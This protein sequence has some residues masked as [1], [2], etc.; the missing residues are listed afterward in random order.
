MLRR[1][2]AFAF[3][4]AIVASSVFLVVRREQARRAEGPPPDTN[5]LH[6]A[7]FYDRKVG[8]LVRCT[9]CPNFCSLSDGQTGI[10]RARRNVGGELYSMVYGKIATAHLDPI[11]KKP[12]FHFLP[13]AQAF[14]LATP[15]CSMRCL[16]CQNWE[17]SQAYPWEIR[18]ADATP[19]QVVDAAVREGARVIAYTYSEP[20]IFY[21]YVLDI[22][23]LARA[24]G[25]RNVIVSNG[26]INPEPLKQ[27]LPYIDAFKV[28]FKA[29]NP[30]FYKEI[31]GG[32]VQ[33]VLEAMKTIHA[34]GAWLEIVTLLVPGKND[35]EEEVRQLA[36]WVRENL[37]RDVPLHFTRFHPQH[38]MRNVP[39]TPER[40]VIRAW[41]IAR[42]EG[43]NF[44]Y[45][46]NID[47]PPGESTYAPSTGAVAIE[48][49]GYFV[50]KS[51]LDPDGRLPSGE[52]IPGVW[53]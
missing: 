24:R 13:G 26:Y 18:T 21:E 39:P 29:F 14:S 34:Q 31:T 35:S 20:V 42:E 33:P 15:G 25:L 4:A 1:L 38:R 41:E 51:N 30:A 8:G 32:E 48:R 40:T 37:G 28:D 9:L 23:K 3:L 43:L 22:A 52:Q 46:G 36:R 2:L 6:R 16:F 19:E 53:K 44:V 7:L 11:E 17:I 45:T 50:V 47:Y 27:L 5:T 49:Q 10:C 12:F